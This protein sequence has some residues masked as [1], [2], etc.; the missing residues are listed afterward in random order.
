[1]KPTVLLTSFVAATFAAFGQGTIYFANRA[2]GLF[3]EPVYGVDPAAP[4]TPHRWPMHCDPGPCI[5]PY[6]PPPLLSGA[7]YTASLWVRPLRSSGSYSFVT[8]SLFRAGNG[9][10]F[11]TNLTATVAGILSGQHA[12]FVVR[13]WDNQGGQIAMWDQILVDPS[14]ARAES[15]PFVPA[16]LGGTN[17]DGFYWPPPAMYGF[18]GFN[19]FVPEPLLM[20]SICRAANSVRLSWTSSGTNFLL[21]ACSDL[22]LAS[23]SEVLETPVLEGRDLIVTQMVYDPSRFY[24]LRRR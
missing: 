8:N 9:A 15:W 17:A 23:W 18:R 11:W 12:E 7:G 16:P 21:E 14:I 24:R 4:T 2:A 1:M 6:D 20:L 5:P 13:A 19:L 3:A 22:G 10:G